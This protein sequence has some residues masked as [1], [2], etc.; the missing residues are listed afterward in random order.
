MGGMGWKY[1]FTVEVKGNSLEIVKPL[2]LALIGCENILSSEFLWV[3]LYGFQVLS[4]TPKQVL[5]FSTG[6][7]SKTV[8]QVVELENSA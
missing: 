6:H 7:F 2:I 3:S 4:V 5:W 8:C 1:D